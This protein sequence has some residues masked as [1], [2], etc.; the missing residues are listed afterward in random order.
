M[1]DGAGVVMRVQ[2]KRANR[3]YLRGWVVW[4]PGA[5]LVRERWLS[6]AYWVSGDV[7][8]FLLAAEAAGCRAE[9]MHS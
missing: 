4:W 6:D 9:M 1:Q 3:M 7:Q 8:T 5:R 2:G